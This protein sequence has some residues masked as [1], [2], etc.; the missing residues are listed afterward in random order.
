M[1][2]QYCN[3]PIPDGAT[4]CPGC[5]TPTASIP[6]Q[7]QVVP[8]QACGQI[9]PQQPMYGQ[10][11]PQ[12]TGTPKL[13]NP[14]A[15]ANWSVLFTPVFGGICIFKNYKTLGEQQRAQISLILTI[16]F[17]LITFVGPLLPFPPGRGMPFVALITWYLIE[18]KKQIN[19]LKSRGIVY[20][21]K[22]WGIPALIGFGAL[23]VYV[24]IVALLMIASE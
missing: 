13:Y 15:A 19:F 6:P 1:N 24:S 17:G 18:P 23:A 5:G 11:V 10:Q 20:E 3:T 12:Q 16:V 2:C 9:P 4:F 8:P 21:K 14:T 22:S 7:G